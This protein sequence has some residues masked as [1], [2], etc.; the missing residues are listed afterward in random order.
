MVRNE[1]LNRELERLDNLGVIID[2]AK[3]YLLSHQQT[4]NNLLNNAQACTGAIPVSID[5]ELIKEETVNQASAFVADL[6]NCIP[7]EDIFSGVLSKSDE[8][9]CNG[10]R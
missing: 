9:V 4:V 5:T 1:K 10:I 6:N 2:I 7:I 8:K 3:E